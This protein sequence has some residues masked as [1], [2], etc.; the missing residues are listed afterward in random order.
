MT[1]IFCFKIYILYIFCKL[2]AISLGCFTYIFY[3]C[4]QLTITPA[5]IGFRI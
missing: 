2:F 5:M 4:T 3:L 1:K